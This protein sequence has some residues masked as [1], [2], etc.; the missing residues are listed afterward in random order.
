MRK[1]SVKI[2]KS[3]IISGHQKV[4]CIM[5]CFCGSDSTFVACICACVWSSQKHRYVEIW[6]HTESCKTEI[7][8][9]GVDTSTWECRSR[10]S[11]QLIQWHCYHKTILSQKMS[12]P[13]LVSKSLLTLNRWTPANLQVNSKLVYF[14]LNARA[15]YQR[16]RKE[17]EAEERQRQIK[18]KEEFAETLKNKIALQRSKMQNWTKFHTLQKLPSMN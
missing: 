2:R 15:S 14:A 8:M 17:T 11:H 4:V 5:S 3:Y 16:W 6:L 18:E 13:F 9:S 10:T 1:L 12:K 7:C